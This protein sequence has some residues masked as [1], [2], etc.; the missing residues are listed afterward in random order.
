M[1]RRNWSG[2][3]TAD[4]RDLVRHDSKD[5]YS[6]GYVC[7][8]PQQWSNE[9]SITK[10][11][12]KQTAENNPDV[13]TTLAQTLGLSPDIAFHDV[14]SLTDP[15]LVALLPRPANALLFVYPVTESSEAFYVEEDGRE[16]DYQGCGADEPVMFYRQ[17][18]HHACGLIGLL[19]CITNGPAA[20]LI[21]PGSHLH[22]LVEEAI[23]LRP[24]ERAELLY[25]SDMLEKA[26]AAAATTGDTSPPSLGEDPGHAFIAFVKGRDGNLWELEGR[27]KG[28]VDRGPLRED[29]DVL[30]ENALQR[31]PLPFLKREENAGSGALRFSCTLLGPRV[32]L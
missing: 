17:T 23:P 16:P 5:L 8:V 10:V 19:H 1:S 13:M 18:I 14:Y 30:S 29:E 12:L 25:N 28:P 22:Q 15:D 31:G 24:T 9:A 11:M 2:T 4:I 20:S 27:R 3:P 21:Q 26:H 6:I 7:E 32:D